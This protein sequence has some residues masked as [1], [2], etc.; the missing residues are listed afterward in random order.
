VRTQGIG[1]NVSAQPV[2]VSLCL[3]RNCLETGLIDGAT[4]SRLPPVVPPECVPDRDNPHE[5]SQL[6]GHARPDN[7]M[8]VVGHHAI[9]EQVN[10]GSIEPGRDTT[11][12]TPIVAGVLEQARPSDAPVNDMKH[13]PFGGTACASRHFIRTSNRPA[14]SH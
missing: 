1:F 5:S 7:E 12:E 3:H 10:R 8:E 4:A 9:G 6:P 2:E 11:Q 13:D 14:N